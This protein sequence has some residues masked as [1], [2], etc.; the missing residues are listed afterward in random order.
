MAN[1]YLPAF[2]F[3]TPSAWKFLPPPLPQFPLKIYLKCHLLWEDFLDSV[4]LVNTFWPRPQSLCDLIPQPGIEPTP[5]TLGALG[6][7][8]RNAAR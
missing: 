1:S 7:N 8:H 5:P 3:P 4:H 2:L 6:L